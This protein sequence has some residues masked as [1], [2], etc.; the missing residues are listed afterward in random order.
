MLSRGAKG[1]PS[2]TDSQ[3]IRPGLVL[4]GSEHNFFRQLI[5][6]QKGSQQNRG[7]I[8]NCDKRPLAPKLDA[9]S[10]SDS[11]TVSK[12][13]P[14]SGR[15]LNEN[16]QDL[17]DS[18]VLRLNPSH[19]A[20][21]DLN[22]SQ[23]SLL[24]D[25]LGKGDQT[26]IRLGDLLS[27]FD[28]LYRE[29]R[30]NSDTN[31]PTVDNST[32]KSGSSHTKGV[33]SWRGFGPSLTTSSCKPISDT[34]MA[35][36]ERGGKE[37]KSDR[38][39]VLVG[40]ARVILQAAERASGGSVGNSSRERGAN[41]A[42]IRA[43]MSRRL[44]ELLIE[45]QWEISKPRGAHCGTSR[46]SAA[47]RKESGYSQGEKSSREKRPKVEERNMRKDSKTLSV[48]ELA[49]LSSRLSTSQKCCTKPYCVGCQEGHT[50]N[51]TRENS[52]TFKDD[53]G[54]MSQISVND[55][56]LGS[57]R[58]NDDSKG[59]PR[60]K[61]EQGTHRIFEK[62]RVEPRSPDISK[63]KLMAPESEGRKAPRP[64]SESVPVNTPD[65]FPPITVS[66][67]LGQTSSSGGSA[68]ETP[69]QPVQ[70]ETT[71]LPEAEGSENTDVEEKEK[72]RMMANIIARIGNMQSIE[73]EI[74]SKSR[75]IRKS[76]VDF[77][78]SR[79]H[80]MIASVQK[81]FGDLKQLVTHNEQ[82]QSQKDLS[83]NTLVQEL[84]AEVSIEVAKVALSVGQ[85]PQT[86]NETKADP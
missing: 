38:L 72:L 3:R 75:T 80:M 49:L 26:K 65:L 12:P 13:L 41:R 10:P 4:D 55:F 60:K 18:L 71:P 27:K 7:G 78:A 62:R 76:I 8:Y 19:S 48:G 17:E 22:T 58:K 70:V 63:T 16:R 25:L 64:E 44:E 21:Q 45:L 32:R 79:L 29:Y 84:N 77:D 28:R 40:L 15:A 2:L 86:N 11:L 42:R 33:S 24:T 85:I 31:A 59:S 6:H 53:G 23:E 14:Y 67:V 36:R 5:K 37:R 46:E 30:H 82:L 69:L 73:N 1:T 34:T 61:S 83:R 52:F 39:R 47:H 66:P 20:R 68:P 35:G 57:L 50:S 56:F 51:R 81:G 43:E 74:K 54:T 9:V